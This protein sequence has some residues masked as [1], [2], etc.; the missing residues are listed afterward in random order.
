MKESVRRVAAAAVVL[1][2]AALVACDLW[3]RGVRE[4]WDQHALTGSV[5]TSFLA[6]AV[7]ALIVDEVVAR[8]QRKERAVTVAVQALIVYGQARRTWDAVTSNA[9][10]DGSSRSPDDEFRTLAIMLLTASPSLFDDPVARQF[11]DE[12]ERFSA[13]VY[14][15]VARPGKPQSDDGHRE[16]PVAR[17]QAAAE[18][19]FARIPG[20]DRSLLE[21]PG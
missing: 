8:R 6:L 1:T 4:W 16:S 21:G 14:Q 20:Q 12:V 13:S 3:V 15:M 11:L 2:I 10:G 5:I 19:L 7:T 9:A 18:P 17:L